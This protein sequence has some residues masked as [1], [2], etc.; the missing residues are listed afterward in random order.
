MKADDD[1]LINRLL[2]ETYNKV[3]PESRGSV[4]N[5][6][7]LSDYFNSR[8]NFFE[9]K[10]RCSDTSD[11]SFF[12]KDFDKFKRLKFRNVLLDIPKGLG[13]FKIDPSFGEDVCFE[14]TDPILRDVLSQKLGLSVS[15]LLLKNSTSGVFLEE[16]E[17]TQNNIQ[18]VG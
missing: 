6:V 3:S 5:V 2:N 7:N 10:S 9:E 13:L 8:E 15:R 17:S 18:K 12:L 4:S 16:I 11:L 1:G 14:I